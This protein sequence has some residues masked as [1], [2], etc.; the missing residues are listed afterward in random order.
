MKI[1][2]PEFKENARHALA[3]PQLQR[4]LGNVRSHFVDKRQ[5]AVDALPEFEELRERG[6]RSRTTRSPT[7]T[8]IS[9]PMRLG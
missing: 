3:D 6:A 1:T 5:A 4:A 7:S 8:S 9:R 2:A